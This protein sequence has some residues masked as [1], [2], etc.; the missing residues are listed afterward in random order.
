MYKRCDKETIDFKFFQDYW[1][2]Y[3][4]FFL[5]DCK[6]LDENKKFWED[7]TKA[8]SELVEKYKDTELAEFVK[9]TV[10]LRMVYVEMLDSKYRMELISKSKELNV[11]LTE[12]DVTNSIINSLAK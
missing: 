8:S 12:I 11:D 10:M 9:R 3:Q 2:L 5:A 1:K 6:N 7:F 4:D